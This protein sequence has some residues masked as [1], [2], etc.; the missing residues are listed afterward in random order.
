MTSKM[1]RHILEEVKYCT[2][3]SEVIYKKLLQTRSIQIID[4]Q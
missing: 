1:S 2:H 4:N 3:M